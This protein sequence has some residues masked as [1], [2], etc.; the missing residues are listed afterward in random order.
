MCSGLVLVCKKSLVVQSLVSQI[1]VSAHSEIFF[2][3]RCWLFIFNDYAGSGSNFVLDATME[4]SEVVFLGHTG[5]SKLNGLSS[6]RT[7]N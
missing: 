6:V 3:H 5:C 7:E 4:H 1:C 2:G